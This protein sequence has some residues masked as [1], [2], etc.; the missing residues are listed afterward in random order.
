MSENFHKSGY[1]HRKSKY[2]IYFC[3]SNYLLR[4]KES[5]CLIKLIEKVSIRWFVTMTI[6]LN[7]AQDNKQFSI[8][9]GLNNNDN[10][11][12][13]FGILKTKT[14]WLLYQNYLIILELKYDIAAE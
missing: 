12:I 9:H 1:F 13:A 7:N 4:Y 10:S 11:L 3:K 2:L 6:E 5:F 8:S 14:N